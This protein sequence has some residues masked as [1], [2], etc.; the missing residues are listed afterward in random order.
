MKTTPILIVLL[1]LFLAGCAS[2]GRKMDMTKM[3]DIQK[4]VTTRAELIE[5]FGS[6]QSVGLD[7]EGRSIAQWI[8]V[9]A[10]SQGQNFIP[11]VGAFTMGF[12]QQMQQLVV[13]FD[14]N[15]VVYNYT[16]NQSDTETGTNL[17]AE[18]PAQKVR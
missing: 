15:N 16:F 17:N 7:A 6:P 4:G 18:K 5:W 9:H 8:Y 2:T 1:V 13:S 11:V 10:S 12:D 3:G 14:E